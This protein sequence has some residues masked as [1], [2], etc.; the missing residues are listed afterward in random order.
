MNIHGRI[1]EIGAVP[2][3][4]SLLC[5]KCLQGKATEKIGINLDIDEVYKD[6]RIIKG[7][8]NK[9]TSFEDDKFDAVLCNSVLEH[10]KYFWMTISEIWRVTKP[11]G[12]VVIGTPGY[13]SLQVE[14]YLHSFLDRVPL[15]N[16]YSD[17]ISQS[18]LTFKIHNAPGD[19]YRFSP[20]AFTEIFFRGMEEVE[21][22]SIMLPPRIIASGIKPKKEL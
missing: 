9:M 21:V 11:G 10:D 13:S 14:T 4:K 5:M 1:L 16:K 19:Y 18:T 3:P 8:A 20:Q 6:F 2:N 7:N 22:H 17:F 12:I 15:I